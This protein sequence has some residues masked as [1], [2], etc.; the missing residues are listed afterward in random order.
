MEDAGRISIIYIAQQLVLTII[1][2]IA[3]ALVMRIFDINDLATPTAFS[4][5]F[6]AVVGIASGLIWRQVA[7][8]HTDSLPTYYTA[9]SGFRML[10]ALGAMLA[11][12]IAW[13]HDAMM[14]F[15][16]VFIAFYLVHLIHHSI[17]FARVSKRL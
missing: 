4:A 13:G 17:F 16:L 15:F 12:Y 11:Y 14:T 1:V 10:L 2:T 6:T 7:L 3:S 5:I 8:H 9:S